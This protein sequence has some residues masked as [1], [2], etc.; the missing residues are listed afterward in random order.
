MT[1]LYLA[2]ARLRRLKC[3]LQRHE[4]LLRGLQTFCLISCII[5]LAVYNKHEEGSAGTHTDEPNYDATAAG[6]DEQSLV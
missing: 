3:C 1:T 4:L 6:R 5:I 2:T